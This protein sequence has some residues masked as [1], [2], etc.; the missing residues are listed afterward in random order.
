MADNIVCIGGNK[1]QIVDDG[2]NPPTATNVIDMSITEQKLARLVDIAGGGSIPG[3]YRSIKQDIPP[4]EKSWEIALGV[5]ATQLNIRCNQAVT[6]NFNS[7]QGD[8][9]FVEAS[10]FPFSI[11]ELAINQGIHTIYIT[12]GDNTTTVKILAFGVI[13]K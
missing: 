11:S 8:N 5:R 1:Y 13:G 3:T 9:I 6:I 10:E 2:Y 12:T 4:R 7:T